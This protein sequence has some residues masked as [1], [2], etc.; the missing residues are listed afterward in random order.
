MTTSEMTP[1]TLEVFKRHAKDA[2]NWAGAPMLDISKE[3][4]GNLTDLKVRG[5]LTT[6]KDEGIEW[7]YFTPAG[8]ELARTLG[9]EIPEV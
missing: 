1:A 6:D 9:Y 8:Y 3:E 7:V 4:R 5:L 2:P